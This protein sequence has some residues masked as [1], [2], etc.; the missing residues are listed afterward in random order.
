MGWPGAAMTVVLTGT[1]EAQA[2]AQ[3]SASALE[4]VRTPALVST[5]PR[6][7]SFSYRAVQAD[8]TL[9]RGSV[10]AESR[11]AAARLLA[12][13]GLLPL[14]L[15]TSWRSARTVRLS[16]RDAALGLRPLATLLGAG[17][18][19][20]RALV[21]LPEL[22]P[23]TWAP[24]LPA[25]LAAVREG[26]PLGG[27]L[28]Q[29]GV[30]LPPVVFGILRAGEAGSG[31]APAVARAADLLEDSAATRAGI[32]GALAYPAML[33]VAGVASVTLLV[34]VVL[35]RFAAMLADLGESLPAS[36]RVVL[37]AA[38]TARRAAIPGL[39]LL[40]LGLFVW[41]RWANTPAGGERWHALLLRA[42]LLGD[43]RNSAATARVCGALAALLD[44]GVPI[45][46]A[47]TS[48]TRA[49]GD[50][51]LEAR[52]RRARER[53]LGGARP[54]AAFGHE[55]ALTPTAVRLV[56]AGEESGQLATMLQHAARIEREQA[57]ERVKA[58]V[59][60]LEPALILGLG[61]VIA[62]VAAALLQ[63]MYSIRPT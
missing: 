44:S 28:E 60:L 62:L 8:G 36:T 10:A 54:S 45:A 39:L 61:G 14:E 20:A 12:A 17:L 32:R 51:A 63:A 9:E 40:S 48:A 59:R 33:A 38:T 56:R 29:S 7:V 15:T 2:A 24:V 13:R 25:T 16:A 31:L 1:P 58:L 52:G 11:E 57:S 37:A 22:A 21:A 26:A 50:H 3:S 42:P 27:A 43:I 19:L 46:T 34:G 49:A 53:I 4:P 47:L 6:V 35:P 30:H 18:P 41:R 55:R 5:M 23:P